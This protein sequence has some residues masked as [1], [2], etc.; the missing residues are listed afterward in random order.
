MTLLAI[1]DPKGSLLFRAP[2]RPVNGRG[3]AVP[4]SYGHSGGLA[5]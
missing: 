3:Y 1:K 4:G 2:A 5:T